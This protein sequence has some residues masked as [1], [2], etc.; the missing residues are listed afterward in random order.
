VNEG[1]AIAL[2]IDLLE[3]NDELRR[4][5]FGVGEN[6]GAKESDDMVRNDLDSL[7]KEVCVVYAEMGVKPVDLVY[8][9]L[10]RDKAL[11]VGRRER[12]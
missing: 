8:D 9:K 11:S 3:V 2:I 10:A 7:V 12:G 4:V 6:L 5:M 1:R